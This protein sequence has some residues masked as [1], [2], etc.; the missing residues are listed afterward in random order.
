MKLVKNL[1]NFQVDFNY[2]IR[3][4]KL[5][6]TFVN[7]VMHVLIFIQLTAIFVI[8]NGVNLKESG[9]SNDQEVKLTQNSMDSIINAMPCENI[10]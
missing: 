5:S 8:S 3:S 10:A 2:L 4:C 7:S 9:L 1:L 6:Q